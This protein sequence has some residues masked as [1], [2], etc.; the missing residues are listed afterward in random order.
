MSVNFNAVKAPVGLYELAEL[1]GESSVDVGTVCTSDNINK[2]ARWKPQNV[3]ARDESPAPI[4]YAQRAEAN[5]GFDLTVGAFEGSQIYFTNID[6]L[7]SKD[8]FVWQY[9]KPKTWF[10]MTDFLSDK[11]GEIGYNHN[12]TAPF[13][14][15]SEEQNQVEV[16]GNGSA[17]IPVRIPLTDSNNTV[18]HLSDFYLSD[19]L[20]VSRMYLGIVLKK[21]STNTGNTPQTIIVT[22]TGLGSTQPL[23]VK[24]EQA[25]GAK[26][27]GDYDALLFLSD[28]QIRQT[29]AHVQ[30]HYLGI[31]EKAVRLNFRTFSQSY[32]IEANFRITSYQISGTNITVGKRFLIGTV[33]FYNDSTDGDKVFKD[34][35][36]C[37]LN[38][39]NAVT[40]NAPDKNNIIG[41]Q[42]NLGTFTLAKGEEKTIELLNSSSL[43]D[44][45]I[46]LEENPNLYAYVYSEDNPSQANSGTPRAVMRSM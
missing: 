45:E 40:Q 22:N 38:S 35:K 3:A 13:P 28:R 5:W 26:P 19:L 44:V 33:Y 32:S 25:S 15:L 43:D 36:L 24:F 10:R 18:L 1:L 23:N 29:D 17:F 46:D 39:M 42:H 11:D 4:T 6:T 2:W 7:A 16:S 9:N 27:T 12:A 34:M 8:G 14:L 20:D 41:K 30:G 37:F 31:S 21:A